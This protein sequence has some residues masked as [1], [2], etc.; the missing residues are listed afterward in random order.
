MAKEQLA[1]AITAA[2]RIRLAIILFP[3]I[4]CIRIRE[5]DIARLIDGTMENL[6]RDVDD[7]LA[8]FRIHPRG[9]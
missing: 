6:R 1:E 4:K 9:Q 2:I 8:Y 7:H 5:P 3:A